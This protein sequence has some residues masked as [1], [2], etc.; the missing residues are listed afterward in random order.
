MN[1]TPSP[2][3]T[4]IQFHGI[5]ALQLNGPQGATAIISLQGAQV[6]S[7]I[8]AGGQEW[9]YLSEK[10]DYSGKKSIRGG[11]PVC[12]PQF[13]NQGNLPKH[14]FVRCVP[15]QLLNQRADEKSLSVT[16]ALQDSDATRQQWPHAFAIELSI[17]LGA[18]ELGITLDVENTGTQ[19]FSFTAALHTYLR[20]SDIAAIQ[21][22][23]LGGVAF[24]DAA[25][26]NAE[27][28]QS[29]AMLKIDGEVD[30]VY[31]AAPELLTVVESKRS[32]AIQAQG[33][34]ET[35]VWNPGPANCAA[36]SDMLDDDH[37]RMICVEAACADVGIAL[38][39]GQHW[40]GSQKLNKC[41]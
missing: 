1:P 25:N 36:L 15:W 10:G 38:A 8:P 33:F 37:R 19:P 22:G 39:P 41:G 13:S 5:P 7:W 26:G 2:T 32:L 17:R 18:N 20:V 23:G 30:R 4:P 3:A 12:F 40:R 21:I 6:L 28:I 27:S 14:G 11:V 24:R 29:E 31:H 16:L 9:L 34:A 35:V